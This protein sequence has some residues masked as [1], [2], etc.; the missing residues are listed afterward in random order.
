MSLFDNI[1]TYIQHN[2]DISSNLKKDAL[3]EKA[4]SFFMETGLP[5]SKQETWR[6]SDILK[7]FNHTYKVHPQEKFTQEYLEN[8]FHCDQA[9]SQFDVYK[10]IN[11]R[12]INEDLLEVRP[13][14]VVVGSIKKAQAQYPELFEAHYGKIVPYN[15]NGLTAVNTALADD[16][17]FIYVPDHVKVEKPIQIANVTHHQENTFSQFR[18]LII[19]GKSSEVS[20][21][22]YDYSSNQQSSIT[23]VVC[24]F[25]LDDEAILNHYNLQNINDNATLINTAFFKQHKNTKN[26]TQSI[27]LNGG[28]VRNEIEVA[29][30]ESGS[31]AD[32]IG[33]YI[34]DKEQKVENQV[35]VK[36]H[37]S[38]CTS[39]QEFKGILD[40][41]SHALFNGHI[42]VDRDAQKTEA[43]QNCNNIAVSDKATINAH[44]FLEIYADDVKCSHGATIGQIDEKALFYLRTRGINEE[45]ANLLLLY[46]FGAK[47]LEYVKHEAFRESIDN[48]IKKRLRGEFSSCNQCVLLCNNPEH[49]QEFSFGI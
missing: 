15:H 22:Q 27:I 42:L 13:N 31:H 3:K 10:L 36:H 30:Q 4:L 19:L 18:N 8:V 45:D 14:G 47:L 25:F 2:E 7:K 46:A 37:T 5:H 23:N 29:L 9:I 33:L 39:N 17:I 16:G 40:D 44:P 35:K 38:N 11:G 43:F 20:L 34:M 41:H 21:I 28:N 1:K 6:N 32:V 24:E 12:F 48:M 26:L 49:Q